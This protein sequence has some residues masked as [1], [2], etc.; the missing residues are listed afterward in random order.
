MI[1]EHKE[2]YEVRN[3]DG[4]SKF[5]YF[6]DTNYM[7]RE[8]MHRMTKDEAKQAVHD[9]TGHWPPGSADIAGVPLA[10]D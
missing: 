2:S 10:R 6:E 1:I 8:V 3:Q 7:R 4:S 9:Y 5:F